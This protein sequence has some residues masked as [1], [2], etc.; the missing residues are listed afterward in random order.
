MEGDSDAAWQ[1]ALNGGCR[2]DLWL[3]LARER[4]GTVPGDAIPILLAAADQAVGHKNR[5]SYRNAARLLSE[6]GELFV[7]GDRAQD[8]TSHLAALRTAH[9]AKR[10]LREELDKAGLP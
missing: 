1:A 3:R 7:E 6:A 4:A 10:A 2:D 5:D 9:R 8:F